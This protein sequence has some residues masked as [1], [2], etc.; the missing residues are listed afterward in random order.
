MRTASAADVTAVGA[1]LYSWLVVLRAT[2]EP[3]Q[4]P[5]V[6]RNLLAFPAL[7]AVLAAQWAFVRSTNFGGADEW[8]L[9]DLGSRG[10]LSLPTHNRPLTLLWAALPAALVPHDLRAYWLFEAA[11]LWGT[12]SLVFLILRRL[13]PQQ[14]RLAFLAGLFCMVWAPSDFLRLDTVL[15]TGYAGFTLGTVL[16]TF[17]YLE[18]WFRRSPIL[19]AA[20]GLCAVAMSR[21]AEAIVP[22]L[23]VAPLLLVASARERSSRFFLWLSLWGGGVVVAVLAIVI[24]IVGAG[25]GSYQSRALGL[26]PSPLPILV[27]LRDQFAFHLAPLFGSGLRELAVPAVPVAVA[28][29]AAAFLLRRSLAGGDDE[30]SARPRA[31]ATLMACGLAVAGLGYSAM[32]L[33]PAITTPAR[34]QL[35]SAP[36]IGLFLAAGACL[37]AGRLP[38]RFR[39]VALALLGG[40]I[41]AEGAARTVAMQKQWDEGGSAYPR[42]RAALA[43]ITAAAPS[44]APHTLVLLIDEA[45]AFPFAFTFRHAVQYLYPD[46]AIGHV[47]G[48]RDYLYPG[49]FTE[50]GFA[51]TPWPAIR[52]PW[53]AFPSLHRYDEM[54]VFRL[55]TAARVVL[56][57]RWPP[58]LPAAPG[59]AAYAPR[60]R[61]R[62]SASRPAAHRI[63]AGR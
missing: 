12:G 4:A 5:L 11:Y 32:V 13:L 53:R 44:F 41:V 24:P 36:G 51:S 2:A 9:V 31:L 63:L 62:G 58:E 19:L 20:S 1:G 40:W 59:T 29:F 55:T 15:L 45:G 21:G 43:G 49:G 38:G 7:L 42:Q 14:P 10:I 33:S 50:A 61:I 6:R 25:Q 54:V 30:W 46:A 27:R 8:L 34:T 17:L 22:L 26:D 60:S 39:D 48:A 18:S 56:E 47:W 3:A 28:V 57:E 16:A 23:C 52:R 35:L 37:I